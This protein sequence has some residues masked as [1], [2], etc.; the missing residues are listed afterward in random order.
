MQ[1]RFPPCIFYLLKSSRQ[2]NVFQS[3]E[4]DGLVEDQS[5]P[6][7]RLTQRRSCIRS[8]WRVSFV[9]LFALFDVLLC[10][11]LLWFQRS[12]HPKMLWKRNHTK[13]PQADLP[14]NPFI[15][16][17]IA[18]P[19]SNFNQTIEFHNYQIVSRDERTSCLHLSKR[20]D[21]ARQQGWR[22]L[23]RINNPLALRDTSPFKGDSWGEVSDPSQ[24]H[25]KSFHIWGKGF[26]VFLRAGWVQSQSRVNLCNDGLD[27]RSSRHKLRIGVFFK[28]VTPGLKN[29][30]YAWKCLSR[31]TGSKRFHRTNETGN[32]VDYS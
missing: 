11:S 31:L 4:F 13:I 23:E 19:S 3:E 20:K 7:Y 2:I 32:Q 21:A 12:F 15:N 25:R 5:R 6:P 28:R 1:A 8:M 17:S 9:I 16:A 24:I 29:A 18:K 10:I 26:C 22:L 27:P 30:R 14:F